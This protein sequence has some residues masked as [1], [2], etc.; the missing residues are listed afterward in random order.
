MIPTAS[1]QFDAVFAALGGRTPSVGNRDPL[2]V[3]LTAALCCLGSCA[4]VSPTGATGPAPDV[5]VNPLFLTF[6]DPN[7]S[8]PD[9][10]PQTVTLFEN[11]NLF[12]LSG[13]PTVIGIL[14]VAATGNAGNPPGS[15]VHFEV[16]IGGVD[17]GIGVTLDMTSPGGSD[18]QVMSVVTA[19][20]VPTPGA[21]VQVRAT[22]SSTGAAVSGLSATIASPA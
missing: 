16:F 14:A 15:T 9:V 2:A 3:A 10:G 11:G 5:D 6:G 17:T 7:P 13:L 8:W 1:N 19:F 4:C 20:P 22:R 18:Q 21:F 12:G